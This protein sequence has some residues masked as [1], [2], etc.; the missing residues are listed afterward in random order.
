[1]NFASKNEE[2][3][4]KI[5]QKR[6]CVS[7]KR[8]YSFKMMNFAVP[9]LPLLCGLDGDADVH[10]MDPAALA[11]W[12]L[13]LGALRDPLGQVVRRMGGVHALRHVHLLIQSDRALQ[14]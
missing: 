3:C 11:L 2:M 5:T 7:K 9:G 10:R 6:N 14:K 4:I 1:M 13:S 12:R 8:N